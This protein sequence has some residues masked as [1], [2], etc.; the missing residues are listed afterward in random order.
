MTDGKRWYVALTQPKSEARA[1]ANLVRQGFAV[2]LPRYRRL[3]RHARKTEVVARPLFP[4]YMFVSLDLARDRWRAV[5]STFGIQSMVLHGDRPGEVAS[6]VIAAIK[7]R[8]DGDGYVQL[9]PAIPFNKG[10]KVRIL[11]GI[12]ED[13]VGVFERVADKKRVAV[14]LQLLGREVLT[15]LPNDSIAAA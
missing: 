2:Y 12:F 9:S 8:E 6:E 3:R 13:A 15:L 11:D 14:L 4:R 10:A 1:Q 5:Q 7:D